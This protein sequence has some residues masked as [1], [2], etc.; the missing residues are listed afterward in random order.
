MNLIE[1]DVQPLLP[2]APLSS[3][4]DLVHAALPSLLDFHDWEGPR[5]WDGRLGEPYQLG[6]TTTPMIAVPTGRHCYRDA[7]GNEIKVYI[8]QKNKVLS[9]TSVFQYAAASSDRLDACRFVLRML[10]GGHEFMTSVN[11]RNMPTA[12]SG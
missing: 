2:R 11:G 3:P 5:G 7:N 8:N 1:S 10:L 9:S 6:N 4:Q 12:C